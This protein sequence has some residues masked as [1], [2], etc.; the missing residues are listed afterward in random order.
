MTAAGL[1]ILN[2]QLIGWYHDTSLEAW[3]YFALQNSYSLAWIV[4]DFAFPDS[5]FHKRITIWRRRAFLR[6]WVS[7]DLESE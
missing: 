3:I 2:E 1:P 7:T 5:N 6:S 4:K